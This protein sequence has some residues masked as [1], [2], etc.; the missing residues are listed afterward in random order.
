MDRY[1]S[2]GLEPDNNESLINING[3]DFLITNKFKTMLRDSYIDWGTFLE[4]YHDNIQLRDMFDQVSKLLN[5][6]DNENLHSAMIP[7][8]EKI[9]DL[10]LEA[11]MTVLL[12]Q[13]M[14][15]EPVSLAIHGLFTTF[16]HHFE[17]LVELF[18]NLRNDYITENK[19]KVKL[20]DWSELTRYWEEK[21]LEY[22]LESSSVILLFL[23]PP[24]KIKS[25]MHYKIPGKEE[26]ISCLRDAIKKFTYLGWCPKVPHKRLQA[27][28]K[29][30]INEFVSIIR[31]INPNVDLPDYKKIEQLISDVLSTKPIKPEIK[32]NYSREKPPKELEQLVKKKSS[33]TTNSDEYN[34]AQIK[35]VKWYVNKILDLRKQLLPYGKQLE[36]YYV[37]S[38]KKISEIN[39]IIKQHLKFENTL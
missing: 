1:Y 2:G 26:L 5:V 14:L 35:L 18:S 17:Y 27:L 8:V 23:N 33:K 11:H 24:K 32:D 39:T 12:K 28:L 29:F 31:S 22:E 7:I 13:F 19:L 9:Y 30:P 3:T 38:A 20:N 6:K 4:I 16:K 25:K 15:Y 37:D 34:Q 21:N 36:M 10:P